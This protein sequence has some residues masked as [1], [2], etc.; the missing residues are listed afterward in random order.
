MKTGIFCLR[1][2]IMRIVLIAVCVFSSMH[3]VRGSE[4]NK[5]YWVLASDRVKPGEMIEAY[6]EV[7]ADT[8]NGWEGWPN[9]LDYF[10]GKCQ[11]PYRPV[12]APGPCSITIPGIS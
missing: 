4:G 12:A 9:G 11:D 6:L 10:T 5:V 3:V 8:A 1:S 7:E 2:S